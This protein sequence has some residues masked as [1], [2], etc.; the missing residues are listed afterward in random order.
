MRFLFTLIDA[1]VEAFLHSNENA[2]QLMIEVKRFI[3][4]LYQLI[5]TI[6]V[7]TPL[8]DLSPLLWKFQN[9]QIFIPGQYYGV[10]E[11]ISF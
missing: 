3:D 4:R 9:D 5:S 1:F 6:P 11:I 8:E 7:Y 10:F 2:D